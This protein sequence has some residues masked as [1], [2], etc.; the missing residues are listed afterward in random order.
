LG[1]IGYELRIQIAQQTKE[2]LLAGGSFVCEVITGVERRSRIFQQKNFVRRCPDLA[3]AAA[4]ARVAGDSR[5]PLMREVQ[6]LKIIL[7]KRGDPR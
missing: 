5:Y 3:R 2:L 7:A 6:L 1:K 4:S